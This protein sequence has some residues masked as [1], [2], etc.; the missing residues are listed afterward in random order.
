MR[1]YYVVLDNSAEAELLADRL[2][3]RGFSAEADGSDLVAIGSALPDKWQVGAEVDLAIY[4]G[5]PC[6]VAADEE[7]VRL[8]NPVG[9]NR[10]SALIATH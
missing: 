7:S 2:R 4:S 1:R 5:G 6:V 10:L 8:M 9:P 3:L